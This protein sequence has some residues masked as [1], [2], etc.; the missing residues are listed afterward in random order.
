MDNTPLI[1]QLALR[2]RFLELVDLAEIRA[3]H[4]ATEYRVLWSYARCELELAQYDPSFDDASYD[5]FPLYSTI[6]GLISPPNS[7]LLQAKF[8]QLTACKST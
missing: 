7:D 4:E 6:D 2:S 8:D 1:Q 5:G 3:E